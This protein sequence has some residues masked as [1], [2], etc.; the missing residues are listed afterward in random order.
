MLD[1]PPSHILVG[2]P[3]LVESRSHQGYDIEPGEGYLRIAMLGEVSVAHHTPERRPASYLEDARRR[4]IGK[5]GRSC[6]AAEQL[7][8]HER[9]KGLSVEL[10]Q[11]DRQGIQQR[12]FVDVGTVVADDEGL[13]RDGHLG[14]ARG[15]RSSY[16]SLRRRRV[17]VLARGHDGSSTCVG[18]ARSSGI[19][20]AGGGGV[21]LRRTEL[22]RLDGHCVMV[23]FAPERPPANRRR[24]AR[25]SLRRRSWRGRAIRN[26]IRLVQGVAFVYSFLGR[27]IVGSRGLVVVAAVTTEDRNVHGSDEFGGL[28]RS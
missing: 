15:R 1:E 24:R 2:F 8:K 17:P 12:G 21:F 19:V 9:A 20:R 26:L 4:L 25:K 28:W 3:V 7:E 13:R 10:C 5:S 16:A 18:R 23:V 11:V 14:R 27:R 6:G 22:A